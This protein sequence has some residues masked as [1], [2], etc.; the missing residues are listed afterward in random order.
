[1]KARGVGISDYTIGKQD[2]FRKL[3]HM[4]LGIV[5]SILRRKKW[6]DPSFYYFDLNAG[7]GIYAGQNGEIITGSPIIFLQECLSFRIQYKAYLMERNRKNTVKLLEQV[8]PYLNQ[9]DISVMQGDHRKVMPIDLR[10]AKAKFG[11]L[12]TDPSGSLPPFFLL[13]TISEYPQYAK[14]D[15]LI[16]LSATALKRA[17][18]SPTTHIPV[19][20]DLKAG[21]EQIVGKRFW[22]IREP[23]TQQQ[24]TFLLGTNWNQYPAYEKEGFYWLSSSRGQEILRILSKTRGEIEGGI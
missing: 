16:S 6:A 15:F 1:M 18:R 19:E 12:Y 8:K 10:G 5:Q 9:G 14:V 21:I 22:L 13:R 23:E 20:F 3:I 4:Q 24:W 2:F 17:R 11:L 7:P